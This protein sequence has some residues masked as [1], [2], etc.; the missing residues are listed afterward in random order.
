MLFCLNI[1]G[2]VQILSLVKNMSLWFLSLI[3]KINLTF[4][5]VF[6]LFELY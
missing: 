5:L 1:I 4:M 3:G 2:G 6:K